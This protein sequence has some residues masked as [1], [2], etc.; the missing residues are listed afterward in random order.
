MCET[1]LASFLFLFLIAVIR[2][3]F[4]PLCAPYCSRKERLERK[5][6]DLKAADPLGTF[7]PHRTGCSV[8]VTFSGED[9]LP[10]ELRAYSV[11]RAL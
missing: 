5:V 11:L 3:S 4:I 7:L 2:P 1:S 9:T 10:A 8:F 6:T